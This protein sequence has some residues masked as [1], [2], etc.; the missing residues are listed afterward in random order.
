[1]LRM[2]L[3]ACLLANLLAVV[4]N[5]Q[6]L[7]SAH[8]KLDSNASDASGNRNDGT[9][10]G[11]GRNPFVLGKV[12]QAL[13][14][15]GKDDYV[16]ISARGGLPIY[17]GKGAPYSV[18]FWVKA[19]KQNNARCYSETNA[20]PG[21]RSQF[22]IGSGF[23]GNGTDDRLAIAIFNDRTHKIISWQSAMRVFDGTW[24]HVAWVDAS[25][26]AQLYVDGV[27]DGQRWDYTNVLRNPRT[28]DYYKFT[29]NRVSLGASVTNARCCFL[30]GLLDDLRIYRFVL[31]AADVKLVM[32]GGAHPSC[33]ASVGH[34]GYGCNLGPLR[35]HATG[36][37]Q[38]G[39]TLSLHFTGAAA[40]A[41]ALML[42]GV[43]V[44]PID[45]ARPFG[46]CQLY[47]SLRTLMP[48]A[49]GATSRA[50]ASRNL[51]VP[52]PNASGLTCA[53]LAFQGFSFAG[54]P[55]RPELSGV[56]V[57]QVGR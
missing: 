39:K 14:F 29:F 6:S 50:G 37:A 3:L 44:A 33:S 43:G 56:V 5:A 38:L 49:L 30:K 1:M 32:Q 48:I 36:S 16:A 8:W 13:A 2:S 24:H 46:G 23:S 42:F 10:H 15:D 47:P 31:S 35:M 52:L 19:P 34:F 12:G 20:T 21:I 17:G 11:F 18:A 27:K 28:P 26:T 57:A 7:L 22:S 9:L 45:L 51:R 4:A 40:S 54:L 55:R 41:P 25:G 53:L